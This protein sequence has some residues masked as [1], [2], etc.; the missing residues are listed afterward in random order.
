MLS[1]LSRGSVGGQ[2][3]VEQ[4]TIFR[5]CD[6]SGEIGRYSGIVMVKGNISVIQ[7]GG[8]QL[9]VLDVEQF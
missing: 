4:S 9:G 5:N 1:W 8:Y 6:V 7:R 3:G 2:N